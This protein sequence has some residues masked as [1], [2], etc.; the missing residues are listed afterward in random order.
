MT[1]VIN[2]FALVLGIALSLAMKS[3]DLYSLRVLADL[4]STQVLAAAQPNGLAAAIV[5]KY[6]G[7]YDDGPTA[8]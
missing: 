2:E 4:K 7:K 5:K 8:A 1:E 3:G 6:G